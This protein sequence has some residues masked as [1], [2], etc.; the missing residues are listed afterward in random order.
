MAGRRS[1]YTPDC[2]KRITDAIALGATYQHACNYGGI[3]FETFNQWRAHRAEFSDAVK[4]AEGRAVIGWLAKIEKA[5][6]EGTWTAAAWKLE[7]RYPNDYGKTVTENQH[8]GKDGEGPI[9][10]IYQQY[11]PK[12]E[13]S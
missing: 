4:D 5:A 10:I 2:V 13:P 6:N 7:R 3:T 8:T 9:E 1:K 12:S 11:Q